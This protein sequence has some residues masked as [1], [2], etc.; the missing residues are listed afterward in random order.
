M[1]GK[2][3]LDAIDTID[4]A[5]HLLHRLQSEG[6]VLDSIEHHLEYTELS[7]KGPFLPIGAEVTIHLIPR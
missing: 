4:T 7:K 3:R 6:W 2:R 1:A 5:T